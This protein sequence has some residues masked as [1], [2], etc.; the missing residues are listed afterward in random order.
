M[1]PREI[2][3]KQ[4]HGRASVVWNL[5]LLGDE[6]RRLQAPREVRRPVVPVDVAAAASAFIPC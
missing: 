1:P 6:A 2:E 4:T 3:L 5:A